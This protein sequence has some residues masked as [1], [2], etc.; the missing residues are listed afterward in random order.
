[1]SYKIPR[2]YLDKNTVSAEMPRTQ[3]VT[4]AAPPMRTA[5]LRD[6][7]KYQLKYVPYTDPAAVANVEL[8]KGKIGQAFAAGMIEL[9]KTFDAADASSQY[10]T[11]WNSFQLEAHGQLSVL[12]DQGLTRPKQVTTAGGLVTDDDPTHVQMQATLHKGLLQQR[13]RWA[14]TIKDPKAR[15]QF[16][17]NSVAT[18]V[19]LQ[20]QAGEYAR[21]KH[22]MYLQGE[23]FKQFESAL[24][25]EDVY[26]VAAM[27]H[28]SLIWTP[29][30]LNKKVN[31]RI[32]AIV[33]DK[34]HMEILEVANGVGSAHQ[35]GVTIDHLR[36][37]L[38]RR[39]NETSAHLDTETNTI[40]YQD[41]LST[42]G[43]RFEKKKWIDHENAKHLKKPERDKLFDLLDAA[44]E[45]IKDEIE[46]GEKK[47]F[48]QAAVNIYS[49]WKTWT[50]EKIIQQAEAQG[51]TSTQLKTALGLRKSA[52]EGVVNS[53]TTLKLDILENIGKYDFAMIMDS[54]NSLTK[55]DLQWALRRR[56]GYDNKVDQW[57][58]QGV[59]KQAM[60]TLQMINGVD[61]S[62]I[63]FSMPG[64]ATQAQ[65]SKAKYL[66]ARVRLEA[67]IQ[68]FSDDP[69]KQATEAWK[70]VKEM[71]RE[72]LE[73]K[74]PRIPDGAREDSVAADP[75]ELRGGDNDTSASGG[76]TATAV[77][78]A[79][80]MGVSEEN[81][82]TA[83]RWATANTHDDSPITARVAANL[84]ADYPNR[85][86]IIAMY[87][88]WGATFTDNERVGV[89]IQ[90]TELSPYDW[91][92]QKWGPSM[93]N[94]NSL[95]GGYSPTVP[96]DPGP[97]IATALPKPEPTIDNFAL[98]GPNAEER[99]L[100]LFEI[101]SE[102]DEI[103]ELHAG[104]G[105]TFR[106][107]DG[108]MLNM[109]EYEAYL[110]EIGVIQ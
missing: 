24:T 88:D 77:G 100:Q 26:K 69:R 97:V 57:Y 93:A 12:K 105:A 101:S 75:G 13:D 65:K 32:T 74:R 53:D 82:V 72:W 1:M 66:E 43:E 76:V 98:G 15:A 90:P 94:R 85:T 86:A 63:S 91:F 34:N 70:I 51:W 33:Y 10:T 79:S 68:D 110:K 104:G 9:G 59:G 73:S 2:G 36:L 44:E 14:K 30:E 50:D 80:G 39:G 49:D 96:D 19:G 83:Y 62:V 11:A 4:R 35:R 87:E 103:H 23:S 16:L 5:V 54:A 61:T 84:P 58:D 60:Q 8:A 64:M 3:A 67:Q 102:R 109:K 45:K 41:Q 31:D 28:M 20:K 18:V 108:R 107:E 25:V 78:D 38:M 21:K 89:T 42:S 46:E 92:L 55:E 27:P 22:V 37:R 56:D 52:Q 17:Q 7:S 40:Y 71:R 47:H 81:Q 95:S 6:P 48:N 29:T 106:L 99:T